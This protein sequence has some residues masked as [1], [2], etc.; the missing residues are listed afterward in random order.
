MDEARLRVP[1]R[2]AI[3]VLV[4]RLADGE[5][6]RRPV[7]DSLTDWYD[8]A[9]RRLDARGVA[10]TN[11]GAGWTVTL[12]NRVVHYDDPSGAVPPA[13]T[14][15]LTATLRGASLRKV[16]SRRSCASLAVASRDGRRPIL[17]VIDD[18]LVTRARENPHHVTVRWRKRGK[19]RAGAILD[20]LFEHGAEA[21][22]P[23]ELARVPAPDGG[24]RPQLADVV[25][26]A[27]AGAV[28]RMVG[29]DPGVRL[30]DDD[31]DV[32][33]LRVATRRLRSLLRTF[34]PR[35]DP[36]GVTPI[37]EPLRAL[38]D[39]LGKVRDADVLRAR[40]V[41][42][43]ERLDDDDRKAGDALLAHLAAE[44]DDARAALLTVLRDPAYTALLD[45]LTAAARDLPISGGDEPARRVVRP[46]ARAPWRRLLR[47]ARRLDDDASDEELHGLRV[48]VKRARYAAEAGERIDRGLARVGRRAAAVQEVLGDYHDAVT[49][50]RWLHTAAGALAGHP[51][52]VAGILAERERHEAALDRRRWRVPFA[53]LRAAGDRVW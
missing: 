11:D 1:P 18:E 13:L 33:Q 53:A 49:A 10:V 45:R 22:T 17:E 2:L 14:D 7:A 48:K 29:H 5:V 9:D 46:L 35:I 51:A 47:A 43:L 28:D 52:F 16:E 30:G 19:R 42:A 50:S 25:R 3:D 31:E 44:R 24:H 38:A 20:V 15:L 40:L 32:H 39:A 27:I 26:G 4:E 41:A 34:E 6:A 12:P 23:A 8:T 36:A 37:T 21:V